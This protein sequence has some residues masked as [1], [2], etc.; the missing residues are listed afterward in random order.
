ME[1]ICYFV[2]RVLNVDTSSYCI[3][4][5]V[6]IA[7]CYG[8]DGIRGS[9]PGGG[10]DIPHPFRPALRPLHPIIQKVLGLPRGLKRP[11][12]GVNHPPHLALGLKKE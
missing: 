10:R 7:T 1:E 3:D 5:A 12:C 9:K 6:C 8:L 4:C 2:L 11:G